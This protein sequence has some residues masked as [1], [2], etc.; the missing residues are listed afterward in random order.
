M[1]A[2]CAWPWRIQKAGWEKMAQEL[3]EG[4][5]QPDPLLIRENGCTYC[6]YY[7]VCEKEF[8]R[9]EPEKP[10]MSKEDVLQLMA[11]EMEGG[12]SHGNPMD[13]GPETGD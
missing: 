10:K 13:A 8:G 7:A 5:I 2:G 12:S 3:G 4:N 6:P 9:L 11:E 1:K